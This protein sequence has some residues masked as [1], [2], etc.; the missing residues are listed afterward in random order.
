MFQPDVCA[1]PW[2]RAVFPIVTV[3]WSSAILTLLALAMQLESAVGLAH[4]LA[5][6][7]H[8]ENILSAHARVLQQCS[9]IA[10]LHMCA[11]FRL[12]MGG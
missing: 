11:G 5:S 9:K 8:W 10:C 2:P 12:G 6:E 1:V 7:R 4:M 3:P